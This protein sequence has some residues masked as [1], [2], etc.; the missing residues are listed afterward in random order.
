MGSWGGHG[1]G[2]LSSVALAPP[3]MAVRGARPG[4]SAGIG[5]P[6]LAVGYPGSSP[7]VVF[8]AAA[9]YYYY[10]PP[11]LFFL[12]LK[13]LVFSHMVD[14]GWSL[15]WGWGWSWGTTHTVADKECS[16]GDDDGDQII[17]HPN[18]PFR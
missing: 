5:A 18:T 8:I 1:R 4:A 11:K 2:T 14:F 15:C 6:G 10:L 17:F 13:L 7:P 9:V 12:P 16:S 3:I